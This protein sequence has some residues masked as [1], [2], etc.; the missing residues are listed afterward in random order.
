MPFCILYSAFNFFLP[1]ISRSI[2]FVSLSSK[3]SVKRSSNGVASDFVFSHLTMLVSVAYI[4]CN[5]NESAIFTLNV[6]FLVPTLLKYF[7]AIHLWLFFGCLRLHHLH[8]HLHTSKSNLS[9]ACEETL[10]F[11]KFTH[12]LMTGFNFLIK[13]SCFIDGFCFIIPRILFTMA[14]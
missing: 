4:R 5:S 7:F 1:L 6:Q 10:Y 8:R 11:W 3:Y 2:L 14:L 9:N 12:P 13:S